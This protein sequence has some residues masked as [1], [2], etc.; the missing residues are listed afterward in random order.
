MPDPLANE[1]DVH[2][3]I[4]LPRQLETTKP[5]KNRGLCQQSE[6]PRRTEACVFTC[7]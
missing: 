5:S 2:H 3:R 4:D 1:L 7:G 6:P